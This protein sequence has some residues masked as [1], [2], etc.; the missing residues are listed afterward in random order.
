MSFSEQT[1]GLEKLSRICCQFHEKDSCCKVKH[2][3]NIEHMY[4]IKIKKMN[5]SVR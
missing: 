2:Q 3:E 1:E 5:I 4:L